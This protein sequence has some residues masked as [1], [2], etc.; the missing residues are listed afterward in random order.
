VAKKISPKMILADINAGMDKAALMN[1]YGLSA[2]QFDSVMRKLNEAGFLAGRQAPKQAAAAFGAQTTARCPACATPVAKG[3][4]ECPKCG[5]IFSKYHTV[6]EELPP[7]DSSDRVPL[8]DLLRGEA[9]KVERRSPLALIGALVGFVIIVAVAAFFFFRS[10]S[11]APQS[12]QKEAKVTVAV[13]TA[14][15]SKPEAGSEVTETHEEAGVQSGSAAPER[16]A[17]S[18]T[19]GDRQ[20]TAGATSETATAIPPRESTLAEDEAAVPTT[21]KGGEHPNVDMEKGLDL[22]GQ[23]MTRDVDRAVRQWTSDDFK[24]FAARARQTLDEASEK[25]LPDQIRQTGENLI[26]QLQLESPETAAEAFRKLAALIRPE[27]N[28]LSQE[29]KIKFIK[30]A[31]EIKRDLET[32]ITR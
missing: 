12:S 16:T 15:G 1:K 29:S 28:G 10:S 26:L 18:P 9:V 20:Q 13:P 30:A 23:S 7:K 4:D 3:L 25:G 32:S 22:L 19:S 27:L 6:A 14:S 8:P 17:K 31:Q 24:R 11:E 2:G 21:E 5:V